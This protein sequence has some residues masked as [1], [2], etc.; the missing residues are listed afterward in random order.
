MCKRIGECSNKAQCGMETLQLGACSHVDLT[1]RSEKFQLLYRVGFAEA[2]AILKKPVDV[3]S[4]C[5]CGVH[6][7][8]QIR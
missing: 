6:V 1:Q 7:E 3:A 4:I 2:I 5:R 8:W